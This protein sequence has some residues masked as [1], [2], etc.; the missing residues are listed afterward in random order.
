M[1]SSLENQYRNIPS[2][3]DNM[4]DKNIFKLQENNCCT[5]YVSENAN[6]FVYSNTLASDAAGKAA[7]CY[8]VQVYSKPTS[9]ISN[10][11][12]NC[13]LTAENLVSSQITEDAQASGHSSLNKLL[14]ENTLSNYQANID[15]GN[16][17]NF[18]KDASQICDTNFELYPGKTLISADEFSD[19][20]LEYLECSDVMTDLANEIWEKK[21][22]FLL[23]SDEE[24]DIKLSE[25]CDG[26]D[27]FLSG[28]PCRFQVS[29]NTMPMDTTIG[30]CGHHSKSK[31]VAVRRDLSTYSQSTLQR[32]MTLTVGHHQDK[33]TTMKDKEKCK[34]PVASTAIENEYPRIE[35]N[36]T[37]NHSAEDFSID[38]SQNMDVVFAEVESSSCGLDS[39][40]TN[41]ASETM[42]ANSMG[43]DLSNK[44]SQQL[45]GIRRKL[46]EEKSKDAVV[47]LTERLRK[48]LLNLLDPKELSKPLRHTG[49]SVQTGTN[50]TDTSAL[51]HNPGGAISKQKHQVTE[52]FLI[53]AGLCHRQ[54]TDKTSHWERKW[55]SGLS[56][57][58]QLPNESVS[59]RVQ[60]QETN[61]ESFMQRYKKQCMDPKI[62]ESFIFTTSPIRDIATTSLP[63]LNM[64]SSENGLQTG[65]VT[66]QSCI[67]HDVPH[68]QRDSDQQ[69]PGGEQRVNIT[70]LS[71]GQ[72]DRGKTCGALEN[73]DTDTFYDEPC[74]EYLPKANCC[75][76]LGSVE[77]Q[78]RDS[79]SSSA[80]D[81]L[82][83]P[84]Y[85]EDSDCHLRCE[86]RKLESLEISP[87]VVKAT[88]VNFIGEASTE[89]PVAVNITEDNE[90]VTAL[91][92]GLRTAME[93]C[94]DSDSLLKT[95]EECSSTSIRNTSLRQTAET[96]GMG[97]CSST[98]NKIEEP[99][100]HA[101]TND[102]LNAKEWLEQKPNKALTDDNGSIRMT[103]AQ[104]GKLASNNSFQSHDAESPP[105]LIKAQSSHLEQ[106]QEHLIYT[107]DSYI[108]QLPYTDQNIHLTN[109]QII[110][111]IDELSTKDSP[112]IQSYPEIKD[113]VYL[114]DLV[115]KEDLSSNSSCENIN[116]FTGEKN[117]SVKEVN[118]SS[119]ENFQEKGNESDLNAQNDSNCGT[120]HLSRDN[121]SEDFQSVS[122]SQDCSYI[123]QL[124]N[125]IRSPETVTYQDRL[126]NTDQDNSKTEIGVQQ[127]VFKAL[128]EEQFLT[129]I[130]L[131]KPK[132][133]ENKMGRE[134]R[135]LGI[136]EVKN[137][138]TLGFPGLDSISEIQPLDSQQGASEGNAIIFDHCCK[139][140]RKLRM[141]SSTDSTY[142]SGRVAPVS[143][144]Q[145][146]T[147]VGNENNSTASQDCKD[148][149]D[150]V[151]SSILST[152]HTNL[153]ETL[154]VSV[155][156]MSQTEGSTVNTLVKGY[157]SV[158]SLVQSEST[159]IVLKGNEHLNKLETTPELLQ[160]QCHKTAEENK[161]TI[162][163]EKKTEQIQ[164]ATE[165]SLGEG[166]VEP[167]MRALITPEE[168]EHITSYCTGQSDP[169][170]TP[171]AQQIGTPCN[172]YR[173]GNTTNS[174]EYHKTRQF[175]AGRSQNMI[176]SDRVTGVLVRLPTYASEYSRFQEEVPQSE[177]QPCSLALTTA[178]PVT[179]REEKTKTQKGSKPC[180]HLLVGP[181]DVKCQQETANSGHS[182]DGGKKK[183]L[184]KVLSKKP[185]LEAKENLSKNS[186]CL[187]KALK[188]NAG[189]IQRKEKEEQRKLP[190]KKNSKA[191]KLLKK[192]HA[193][194]FPDC[195]GNIKLCCQ[196]GEIHEDSIVTWIKDSKLLAR[197]NRSAGDDSPVSLAIVQTSIKD[198][199]L[200][201][202]C[203]KNVYGKV[204]AEFNLNSEV[205]K[206][207]SSYQDIEGLEE[208]EFIQLMFR[209]DFI[210]DSYFGGNLHGRIATEELHFGEG[211]HRK[212]F[213]SK[214]MQGLVPIFSPGH[215]CVLK[216]H[217]AISYGTKTKDELVQKNYKL[218]MQECYVQNTAR[219]YAKIYAAEA[220]SLEGFGE[221]P[222]II[223]IF[224]VH[225]PEN[226][227]PYATVEEELIGEFVKYSVRDGKEINFMRKDSE[228]GQKCCTF[229]H[230]LYE[231][232]NGN[233]LV[234]DFQGVGMKLTDV[235][236]ATLAK[237]YKGFKGNCAISFIDQFKALH[238][239]NKYCEM[240]GLKSLP[241][242]HQKQRKP[243]AM[244][245]KVPPNSP[246]VQK[247]V[248]STQATK[249]T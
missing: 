174:T 32:G 146:I 64:I 121:D 182:A 215:P 246:N 206:H 57:K 211:V 184:S 46:A 30:F 61:T 94:S 18:V 134:K 247:R 82:L 236:I 14:T 53:Q 65:Y 5:M 96:D 7:K 45:N 217:T 218:A 126:K 38:K 148:V 89:P 207:L 113:C 224:L 188:A 106:D 2:L 39:S 108:G 162:L 214:V 1:S 177:S 229:Q 232:T 235:G 159:Q 59:P 52:S 54:E 125:L 41:Q 160:C 51:F 50:V 161:E 10:H 111:C 8:S 35:E 216:V 55:T 183:M 109:D 175:M 49:E 163:C 150:K 19:D 191:P 123:I 66:L 16:Q 22:K 240:L 26:C 197:V 74:N 76:I 80:H 200:Y 242:G 104:E 37:N 202:C 164:E 21:L 70:K 27:Y 210:S 245:S 40:L 17:H 67:A 187:K 208:I 28:M 73:S 136:D 198:Q 12:D 131:E 117:S 203:L 91:A 4:N 234:T 132:D 142:D 23:E 244:K 97:L 201:Y 135:D 248:A 25:D 118:K 69:Q 169:S 180:K 249:T 29:D 105:R 171:S 56:D 77:P 20:D 228:A 85:E 181:E 103:A 127:V 33:T 119:E 226:N 192:I 115:Q 99:A 9:L 62:D 239:C 149:G 223:P 219:E 13:C 238:Q 128:S 199:G 196:F 129:E 205:L 221:V 124:H 151:D 71:D 193:E 156:P 43:K 31:E 60:E 44:S 143:F 173:S 138:A 83:K 42:V 100:T 155:E 233:L 212:A 178:D 168:E 15:T 157:S 227:V 101:L 87:A 88:A 79:D 120:Y 176:S 190:A 72:G 189:I 122:D 133:E 186:S 34:L 137:I 185:R 84:L 140:G 231:K 213:R 68:D 48:D 130:L 6:D 222:E 63:A 170:R 195:S 110:K 141:D 153:Q 172:T 152:Q 102:I 36:N 139:I 98:G 86:N 241:G 166:E 75:A 112:V 158:E 3:E 144:F 145:P 165:Y 58:N 147:H 179:L 90:P 47:N 116:Q 11:I 154:S 220:E 167:Y 225:R 204:T 107:P 93:G 194:L 237:G 95:V 230:W 78:C 24:E 243:T 209:E 92:T 81:K 114:P